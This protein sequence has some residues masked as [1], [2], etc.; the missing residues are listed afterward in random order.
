M[1]TKDW[2]AAPAKDRVKKI[3][4]LLEK[5]HDAVCGLN[6]KNPFQLLAAT[7]LSAQS[8]DVK[9]NQ[10][11]PALFKAYPNAET[12]AQADQ[13]KVESLIKSSGFYRQKAK[14]I[15][16]M[17]QAL[18]EKHNGN[19]PEDMEALVQLPGTGRK[20]ANV[21]LGTAYGHPAVFVDTHVKRLANKL[22]LTKHSNPDKIE[23]DL[24]NLIS[25]KDQTGF[26]HRL[27]WHGRKVCIARKPKCGECVIAKYC[28]SEETA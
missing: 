5:E 1:P 20:T 12:L 3:I 21:V 11:T 16:G 18:V 22:G 27:I 19:V 13:E 2:K 9:I 26:C 25:P 4:P 14:S 15:I 10:I 28:P 6:F 7:I 24:L 17:A 23:Q 8:T